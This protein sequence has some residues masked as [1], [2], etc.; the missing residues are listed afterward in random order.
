MIEFAGP[1]AKLVSEYGL[2]SDFASK[3]TAKGLDEL[4]LGPAP[5]DPKLQREVQRTIK[6]EDASL[7]NV[8]NLNLLNGGAS[9]S[10]LI[11]PI[12]ST[13]TEPQLMDSTPP[14]DPS[15]PPLISPYPAEIPP[16]PTSMRTIDVARE[17]EKVREAR[18]RIKLGAEAYLSNSNGAVMNGMNGTGKGKMVGGEA[19]KPSVCLFTIHDAGER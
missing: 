10:N 16:Y 9:T 6:D 1:P 13:S 7:T 14:V 12:A 17:V 19:A 18:K 11:N 5:I 4:K 8:N 2:V 15:L 3:K